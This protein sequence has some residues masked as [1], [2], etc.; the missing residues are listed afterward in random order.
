M[1]EDVEARV[2]VVG[3]SPRKQVLLKRDQAS[4]NKCS[5]STELQ[6]LEI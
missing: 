6:M 5:E 4:V 2:M 3:E 1:K